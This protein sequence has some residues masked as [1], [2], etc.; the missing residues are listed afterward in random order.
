[1]GRGVRFAGGIR[2]KMVEVNVRLKVN[3]D[4]GESL[5]FR[6]A[7]SAW[8]FGLSTSSIITT[9]TDYDCD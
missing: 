4:G 7:D 1:M 9:T 2:V 3:G 6:A 5:G 8:C